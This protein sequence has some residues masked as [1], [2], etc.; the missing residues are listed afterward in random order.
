MREDNPRKPEIVV[1][2]WVLSIGAGFVLVVFKKEYKK[3]KK[4][5]PIDTLK[6]CRCCLRLDTWRDGIMF[7]MLTWNDMHFLTGHVSDAFEILCKISEEKM[8]E[9]DHNHFPLPYALRAYRQTTVARHVWPK[10]ARELLVCLT[11]ISYT[12]VCDTGTRVIL[13]GG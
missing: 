12:S 5:L 9:L 2:I 7:C 4:I 11:M 10:T 8:T 6:S 3:I 13:P 1:V